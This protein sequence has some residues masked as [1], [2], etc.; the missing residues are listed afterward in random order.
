MYAFYYDKDQ[1]NF[2]II[3]EKLENTNFSNSLVSITNSIGNSLDS[4]NNSLDI[5]YLNGLFCIFLLS[6]ALSIL[7]NKK[8]NKGY[9]VVN[10]IEPQIIKGEIITKT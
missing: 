10:T 6:C 7:C 1:D 5:I 4:I 8:Q 3:E 2:F 9:I